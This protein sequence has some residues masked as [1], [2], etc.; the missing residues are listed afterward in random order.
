MWPQLNEMFERLKGS[1]P[2]RP[3]LE[4]WRIREVKDRCPWGGC[5]WPPERDR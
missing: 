4:A 2:P 3:W 1:P 5:M